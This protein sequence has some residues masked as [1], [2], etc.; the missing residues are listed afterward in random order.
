[1]LVLKQNFAC[2]IKDSKGFSLI[3]LMIVIA[4]IGIISAFA[5]PAFK[6]WIADTKTRTVAEA[7]QNGL[8]LAQTEAVRR[9]VQVQFVLTDSAPNATGVTA[10]TTGRNWVVQSMLRDTPG[11]VDAFIQGAPL[12]AVSSASLVTAGSATVTFNSIGRVVSPTSAVTYTLTNANGSRRL[13]IM[14]GLAGKIR[15]CDPD[16]NLT[17]SPDGCLAS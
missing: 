3:E 5:V 15:M 9:G 11:T 8:R 17:S 16:R 4:I 1:M 14:L 6:T 7:L 2:A 12:G 10:S 13:K